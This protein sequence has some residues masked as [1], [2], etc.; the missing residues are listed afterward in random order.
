MAKYYVFFRH[1]KEA[2][3]DPYAFLSG[4]DIITDN[5]ATPAFTYRT[6]NYLLDRTNI[7]LTGIVMNGVLSLDQA[8]MNR[9]YAVSGTFTGEIVTE[10]P[11]Q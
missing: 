7:E 8:G 10:P 9:G 2:P 6:L 3:Y 11:Q 1:W 5:L 4:E